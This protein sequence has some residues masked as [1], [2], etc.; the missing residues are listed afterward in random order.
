MG[1]EPWEA[2]NPME[3]LKYWGEFMQTSRTRFEERLIP[4]SQMTGCLLFAYKVAMEKNE[5]LEQQLIEQAKDTGQL[6]ADMILWRQAFVTAVEQGEQLGEKHAVLAEQFAVWVTKKQGKRK[7]ERQL[8]HESMQSLQTQIRIRKP[9]ME[10]FGTDSSTEEESDGKKKGV[11]AAPVFK[12][13]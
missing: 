12:K 1:P 5:E 4:A 8:A 9:G 11:H 10:I 7:T 6:R 3:A 2:K 13:N